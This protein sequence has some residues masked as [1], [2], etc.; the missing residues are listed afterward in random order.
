MNIHTQD[1]YRKLETVIDPEL[2]INIVDLGLI[3]GV[4]VERQATSDR[5]KGQVGKRQA[6]YTVRVEMTL[7]TPGCPLAPV[8]DRMVKEAVSKL[9]GVGEDDVTVEVTF[10]PPWNKDMMSEEARLELG[11]I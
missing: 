6:K 7:T 4:A 10:D 1:V 9:D 3:Y 2:H 8:I 5:A 11:I